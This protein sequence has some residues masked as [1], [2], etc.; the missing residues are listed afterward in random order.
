[1]FE[2]ECSGVEMD[3]QVAVRGTLVPLSRLTLV[4]PAV[5]VPIPFIRVEGAQQCEVICPG[6]EEETIRDA[7]GTSV[8][9]FSWTDKR[10]KSIPTAAAGLVKGDVRVR[11]EKAWGHDTLHVR[12]PWPRRA[13]EMAFEIPRGAT[14]VRVARA[15]LR[16][17][18]LPRAVIPQG[19]G[20]R[21][22]LKGSGD[23]VAEVVLEIGETEDGMMALP[24]FEG[25]VGTM[26]VELVGKGWGGE[27][28][29]RQ[30]PTL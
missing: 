14:Y 19:E 13:G 20:V 29:R 17:A 28:E 1:L 2:L 16:G 26:T 27:S 11:V 3:K 25:A 24:R 10:G 8:G 7:S 5:P 6:A 30:D 21:V 12:F 22:Q 15:Q 23:G 9:V 4:S 18:T